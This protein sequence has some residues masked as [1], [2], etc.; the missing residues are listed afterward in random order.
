MDI[1]VYKN[2]CP[3]KTFI[4]DSC[5]FVFENVCRRMAFMNNSWP[6]VF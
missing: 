1:P 2:A 4:K 6:F 3:L 5:P